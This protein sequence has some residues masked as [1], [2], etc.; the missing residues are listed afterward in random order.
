MNVRV[1]ALAA[2]VLALAILPA[3]GASA[4]A[5]RAAAVA[6]VPTG[7][8]TRSVTVEDMRLW[9]FGDCERMTEAKPLI[10]FEA[11][12]Q[13]SDMLFTRTL[14]SGESGIACVATF[15][16]GDQKRQ[17]RFSGFAMHEACNLMTSWA[18]AVYV[19]PVVPQS[20]LRYRIEYQH[21]EPHSFHVE[22]VEE[23]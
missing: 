12:W 13:V 23:V 17:L 16:S 7:A 15:V 20:E 21:E 4:Q 6:N 10:E 2:A 9:S 5:G 18:V 8:A 22:T 3:A 1:A 19:D 14:E 11:G